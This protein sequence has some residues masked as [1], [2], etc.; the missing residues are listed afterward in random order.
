[1]RH[2]GPDDRGV[3]VAPGGRAG[4]ANVRLAIRD[5]SPAGHMPMASPDGAAWISYNGEC[6]NVEE[7]RPEL[8]RAGH[9]FRGLSDTEVLLAGHRAWG[10]GLLGRARGMFALAIYDERSGELLLARDREPA[11]RYDGSTVF[12][13]PPELWG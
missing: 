2:R 1:M 4:L 10:A 11:L 7:L 12:P 3:Y 13:P 8:E 9:A 6:Y 5:C